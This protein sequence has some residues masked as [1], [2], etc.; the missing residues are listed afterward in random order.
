MRPYPRCPGSTTSDAPSLAITAG[1][2]FIPQRDCE[3]PGLRGI[4]AQ[5]GA[6]ARPSPTPPTAAE[7]ERLLRVR[8][9][10]RVELRPGLTLD[11][12]F[13]AAFARAHGI[14]R[15]ALFGSALGHEF[16][17][18]SDIDLLVEFHP[19]HT[20]GLLHL[21]QMELELED[22]LGRAVE[23]RTPE[24]LSPYFRGQVTATARPLYAA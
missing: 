3:L 8:H 5:P 19:E 2:T 14:R 15:L 20:P 1:G 16:S 21:P 17:Q 7:R 9:H 11:D 10:D 4:T 18:D 6:T 23:L 13:L 12:G 24:D 22:A